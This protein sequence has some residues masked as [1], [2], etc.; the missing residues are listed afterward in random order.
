MSNVLNQDNLN[1][2]TDE[3]GFLVHDISDSINKEIPKTKVFVD[4]LKKL[5]DSLEKISLCCRRKREKE[6]IQNT[7][8]IVET[9]LEENITKFAEQVGAKMDEVTSLFSKRAVM[10]AIIKNS[11]DEIAQR[12]QLTGAFNMR[13]E[14][15]I[16]SLDKMLQEFL[17]EDKD[18]SL[19]FIDVDKLK[20]LND[21]I[22]KIGANEVLAKI[23]KILKTFFRMTDVVGRFGGDEFFALL[24]DCSIEDAVKVAMRLH[25]KLND[26]KTA[27]FVVENPK[28][29]EAKQRLYKVTVSMSCVPAKSNNFHDLINHADELIAEA[30]KTRNTICFEGPDGKAAKASKEEIKSFPLTAEYIFAQVK[31]IKDFTNQLTS[32]R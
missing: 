27:I 3:I 26:A 25:K 15:V 7:L 22:G 1:I 4:K 21:T 24:P 10:D 16:K 17:Q 13:N 31:K 8:K 29:E 5:K 9:L 14:D 23:G 18:I 2:I 20:H 19:I 11:Q 32:S 6:L 28:D 30:K 12:D